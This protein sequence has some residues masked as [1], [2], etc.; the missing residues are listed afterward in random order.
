MDRAHTLQN[1]KR[2][3]DE[4][5]ARLQRSHIGRSRNWGGADV[6]ISQVES[7]PGNTGFYPPPRLVVT[8]Y[9]HELSWLFEQ[10]RDLF[11]GLYD[12][13]SKIEFFGRLANAALRY[14]RKKAREEDLNDLLSAVLHEAFAMADEFEE[15]SFQSFAVASGNE[16]VD[17]YVDEAERHGFLGVEETRR[18][19][20]DQGEPL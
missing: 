1:M 7:K 3:L 6:V 20:A 11:R 14:Q 18:F 10:L 15:G 2:Q 9:S 19:F 8:Q 13:Q 16:I 12:S 17:D 5:A 4:L